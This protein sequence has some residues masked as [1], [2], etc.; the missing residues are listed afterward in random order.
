M[1]CEG[2]E[3][4]STDT[5]VASQLLSSQMKNGIFRQVTTLTSFSPSGSVMN[6][7]TRG[8]SH[9]P[10]DH[11]TSAKQTEMDQPMEKHCGLKT[12]FNSVFISCSPR[13]KWIAIHSLQ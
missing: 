9:A 11:N 1:F 10:F 5:L 2:T 12:F 7:F 8:M 6:F 4:L 13:K 3:V